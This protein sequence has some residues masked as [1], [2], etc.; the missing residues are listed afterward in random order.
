MPQ[1]SAQPDKELLQVS[2]LQ[3]FFRDSVDDAMTSNRL[4][5]DSHTSHYVVNLLTLFARAEAFHESD[6]DSGSRQ[7]LALM[8]ANALEAPT[9]EQR[10][11]GLQRLGD[12]SLF[13][14]GFFA[15]D[16]QHSV[17]DMDYY[18]SMGA[19]A[20]SS[21]SME[22]RGTLQ[23]KAFGA[24]FAELG[25]KFQCFVDVLNDVRDPAAAPSDTDVMRQYELWLKTGSER[26]ARQLRKQGV[27]PIGTNRCDW[28]H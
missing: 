20:Y 2:N 1:Q 19:G 5:A 28:Q 26:A 23:G 27:H 10:C 9:A 21:L 8:L 14:A 6:D 4:S 7:P 17:V 25:E 12:I 11:Y 24:V 22:T 3:E 13:V 15:E 16:L 18:V